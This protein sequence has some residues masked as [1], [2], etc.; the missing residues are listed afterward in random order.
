MGV[1]VRNKKNKKR[2][3]NIIYMKDYVI[4][5]ELYGPDRVE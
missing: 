1:N 4:Y 5:I 2:M 3:K